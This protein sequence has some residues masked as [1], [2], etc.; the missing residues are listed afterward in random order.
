MFQQV[1]AIYRFR[2]DAG[3]YTG[4]PYG[5]HHMHAIT[6]VTPHRASVSLEACGAGAFLIWGAM[7]KGCATPS[8]LTNSLGWFR[9]T[10]LNPKTSTYYR[11]HPPPSR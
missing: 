1:E 3:V 4:C 7:S 10:R 5:G 8:G 9:Q 6:R 2:A 11:P